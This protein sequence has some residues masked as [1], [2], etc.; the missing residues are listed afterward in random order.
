VLIPPIQVAGRK[1]AIVEFS[2]GYIAEIHQT[3]PPAQ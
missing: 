2:G 1:S 3:V